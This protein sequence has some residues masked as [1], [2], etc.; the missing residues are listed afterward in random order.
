VSEDGQ[1]WRPVDNKENNEDLDRESRT[2]TFAVAEGDPCRF[3]R[4]V[5]IGR[6]QSG[7]D[8][9]WIEAWEIFGTLIE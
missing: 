6:N 8:R 4:L 5:Q 2:G 3:I 1:T 7:D 9:L